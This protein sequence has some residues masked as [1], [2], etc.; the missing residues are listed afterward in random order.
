MRSSKP[1]TTAG[2][3]GDH[4]GLLVEQD[5]EAGI[6]RVPDCC[7]GEA[8]KETG[9]ARLAKDRGEGAPHRAIVV[10]VALRA[11]GTGAGRS[12]RLECPRGRG[13]TGKSVEHAPHTALSA[14]SPGSERSRHLSLR[15]HP[16]GGCLNEWRHARSARNSMRRPLCL[17]L[18]HPSR[19]A[20]HLPACCNQQPTSSLGHTFPR[21]LR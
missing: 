4:L 1:V 18:L 6:G 16:P 15:S 5:V 12:G 13:A 8:P 14:P 3:T 21:Q 7:R 11:E 20:S 17:G 10:Q 9:H 19:R 2:R